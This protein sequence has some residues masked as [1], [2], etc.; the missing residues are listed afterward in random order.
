MNPF[1][2]THEEIIGLFLPV[3]YSQTPSEVVDTK[4]A[5]ALSSLLFVL[6]QERGL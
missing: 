6:L 1:L 2:S 5:E 3:K 4:D